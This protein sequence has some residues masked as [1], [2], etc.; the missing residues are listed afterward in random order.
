MILTG[1][2]GRFSEQA[3][4]D[5]QKGFCPIRITFKSKA[6]KEEDLLKHWPENRIPE[7][8]AE[9][10]DLDADGKYNHEMYEAMNPIEID[11]SSSSDSDSSD[12]E[13]E[14]VPDFEDGPLMEF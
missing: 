6:D 3:K 14:E 13:I 9:D 1:L 10:E 11:S 4:F 12:S 5:R 7:G 8:F 2:P